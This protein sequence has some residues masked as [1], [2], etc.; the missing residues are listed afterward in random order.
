MGAKENFNQ[1]VHEVFSFHKDVKGSAES[2]NSTNLAEELSHEPAEGNTQP[3]DFQKV[4]DN[5]MQQVVETTHITKDT[6]ITG[7][8]SSKSN[9]EISGVVYGDIE[10]QNSIRVSGKIEGNVNGKNVE[11]N[12]ATVKGDIHASDNLTITNQSDIQ[13]NIYAGKL[14]FNSKINGNINVK[15]SASIQKESTV[16]GDITAASINVENGAAIK[17]TMNIT[18]VKNSDNEENPV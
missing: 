2:V 12:H 14:E 13:G 3:V 5:K 17:S 4:Y 7:S 18:G 6:K 9:L 8:I 16:V 15:N 1:A 11:I 10:S